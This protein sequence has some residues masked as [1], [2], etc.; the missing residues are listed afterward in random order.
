M[1][2]NNTYVIEEY[3]EEFRQSTEDLM[4]SVFGLTEQE[5]DEEFTKRSYFGHVMFDEKNN[6]IASILACLDTL[7]GEKVIYIWAFALDKQYQKRGLERILLDVFTKKYSRY[8][9]LIRIDSTQQRIVNKYTS[10]GFAKSTHSDDV[11]VDGHW[12][13][14]YERNKT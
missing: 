7:R 3:R 2:T 10:L 1:A 5:F 12:L 4:K 9:I 13:Y 11:N 14:F 8:E 6:I